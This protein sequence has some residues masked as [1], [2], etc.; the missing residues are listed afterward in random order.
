MWVLRIV[1]EESLYLN[2]EVVLN[3][4]VMNLGL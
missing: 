3:V 4:V 2:A 1:E